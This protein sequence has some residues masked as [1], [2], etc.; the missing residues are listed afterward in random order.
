MGQASRVTQGGEEKVEGKASSVT[1]QLL[2]Y[3]EHVNKRAEVLQCSSPVCLH[4]CR[5]GAVVTAWQMIRLALALLLSS[6]NG[7]VQAWFEQVWG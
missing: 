3:C 4:F 6:P 2:Q 5:I 7:N 1:L